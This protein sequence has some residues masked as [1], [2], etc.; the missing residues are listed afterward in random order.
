V[1]AD[2]EGKSRREPKVKRLSERCRQNAENIGVGGGEYR[3]IWWAICIC[4]CM[5]CSWWRGRGGEAIMK[6][7][8]SA[9]PSSA[10][11]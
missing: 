6:P 11:R 8:S 10:R 2:Y 7:S 4:I 5:G 9:W 1:D 3:G